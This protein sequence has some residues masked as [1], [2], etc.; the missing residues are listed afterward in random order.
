MKIMLCGSMAFASEMKEVQT[1]LKTLGHTPLVA[2]DLDHMIA[3]PEQSDDLDADLEHMVEGDFL[4]D[5]L[6]KIAESEAILVLNYQ[7][8]SIDGYIGTSAL[9]EMAVAYYLG[10][11]IFL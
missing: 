10:K 8:N 3:H 9:M 5:A 7:K 6:R 11:K 4:R 1:R 2:K